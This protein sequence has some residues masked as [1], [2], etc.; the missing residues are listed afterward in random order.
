MPRLGGHFAD[1]DLGV[2]I[3]G[4]RQTVV[5]AVAVQHVDLADRVQLV[6]LQPCGKDRGHARIEP[7]S[8]NGGQSLF[9]ELVLVGPLP[10]IFELGLVLGLVVRGIQ[11]VHARLQTGIHQ[12]QVLIGQREVDQKFGAR[13]PDQFDDGDP[14]HRI[15]FGRVNHDAGAFL[16]VLGDL[17]TFEFSARGQRDL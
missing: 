1:V 3:G 8:Q 12:R 11:I 15:H 10:V 14:V 5:T 9:L 4:K 13:L 2:E 6:F 7:R 16:D 17:V